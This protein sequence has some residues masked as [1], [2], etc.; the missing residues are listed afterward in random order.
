[1]TLKNMCSGK[2]CSWHSNGLKCVAACGNSRG[3]EC[4]NGVTELPAEGENDFKDGFDNNI[5]DNI[6][7]LKFFTIPYVLLYSL[8][9]F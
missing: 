6:F 8:T 4:E 9:S 3:T 1:M 7:D 5:F 2:Q